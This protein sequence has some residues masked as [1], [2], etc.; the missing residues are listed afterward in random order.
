MHEVNLIRRKKGVC[1]I[2]FQVSRQ[3]RE[4]KEMNFSAGKQ[5]KRSEGKESGLLQ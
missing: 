5:A 3:G 2:I 1:R 4:R